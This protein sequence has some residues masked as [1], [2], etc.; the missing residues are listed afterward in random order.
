MNLVERAKKIVL[1]PKNEWQAI[2]LENTPVSQLFASYLLILSLIPAVASIIGYGFVGIEVPF[3]GHIGSF[4]LG[5]RYAVISLISMTGGA[6]LSAFIINELAPNFGSVKNFNKAFELVV[7]S[8]TPTMIAG[9]FIIYPELSILSTLAGIYGL[10]LLYVG[11]SPMMKTS[12]EKVMGYFIV[13]L[14]V[15]VLVTIILSAILSGII[16]GSAGL[17][18]LK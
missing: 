3:F 16:I 8:Y 1:N 6:L 10:Y 2:E 7:Y 9:I 12:P 13:S 4:S 5:I 17:A 11:I 14:V 18:V 15:T